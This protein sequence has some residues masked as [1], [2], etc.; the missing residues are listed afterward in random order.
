MTGSRP[1]RPTRRRALL[2]G[3]AALLTAS[4]L[5]AVAIL[6]IDRF[7]TVE[8]RILG[9]T[10]L[11]GGF[12]LLALPAAM[13]LDLERAHAL[14]AA[15]LALCLGGAALTVT[16]VWWGDAP[17][18]LGKT[19][20]TAVALAAAA[21]QTAALVA[22]RGAFE[23]AIVGRLLVAATAL[24]AAV[25]V[26]F[27][28]MIWADSGDGPGPR[29]LGALL[30]LDLLAAALQPI[31]ARARAA[32]VRVRMRVTLAPAPPGGRGSEEISADGR[33]AAAAVAAGI[34]RAERDGGAVAAVEVIE[35]TPV[36]SG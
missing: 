19:T 13:L 18:W 20:G 9:T 32:G 33:D 31:L 7:G 28:A 23:P 5:L 6:L 35:R 27:S 29:I 30:V 17:T 22:R 1:R 2:L 25:V 21:A 34:R 26:V 36:A 14:A 8:G 3:V 10:A 24:A 4:A 16:L 11:L 15:L 12:G